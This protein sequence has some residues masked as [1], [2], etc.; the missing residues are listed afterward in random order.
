MAVD[1][2][3]LTESQRPGYLHKIQEDPDGV[4][5]YQWLEMER[6]LTTIQ[7]TWRPRLQGLYD[8]ET[9][10]LG[11]LEAT[12]I[13]LGKV[14]SALRYVR[15]YLE[16]IEA[17]DEQGREHDVYTQWDFDINGTELTQYAYY[18]ATEERTKALG[19][20]YEFV[21]CRPMT[22]G[23]FAHSGLKYFTFR[24]IGLWFEVSEVPLPT[25][26]MYI[27]STEIETWVNDYKEPQLI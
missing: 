3:F 4:P 17:I 7:T 8:A 20:S 2:S 21:T 1:F 27:R 5:R 11:P 9:R 14:A 15:L 18:Y 6:L 24:H 26:E 12:E 25:N 22:Y 19:R 10:L 23:D 13:H 16:R